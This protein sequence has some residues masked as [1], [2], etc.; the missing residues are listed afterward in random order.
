M[1]EPGTALY[2]SKD[3]RTLE[4]QAGAGQLMEKAGMAVAELARDLLESHEDSILIIA[5]PGNNGGDAL[6][7]ARYLKQNWHK[8]T[9]ALIAEPSKLP[10]DAAVACDAWIAAGGSLHAHIPDHTRFELVIDGLFGIGLQRPLQGAYADIVSQINQLTC[11]ILSI[12]TPSGLDADT[13]RILGAAVKASH[14]LTFLGLKPGLYTLEGPDH[15]GTIL[16]SDLGVEADK[17]IASPGRLLEQ[18]MFI[19]ALPPR[20][21]NSHK[22]TFGS[23]A[24]VGG[25]E[26]MTGAALLSARAALLIGSG[27]VYAGLLSDSAPL[28]DPLHPELMLRRAAGLEQNVEASCA[29]VGPG[30]GRSSQARRSLETWLQQPVPLVLDADALQLIGM[31]AAIRS[32]LQKRSHASVITPHPGEAARLLGRSTAEI[33][34]DRIASALQLAHELRVSVVLKG[35]GT[36]CAEPNGDWYIN[37]TGNPGLASAGTGDVLAGIIGGLVA[38]GLEA[39]HAARLGVYLHGAAADALVAQGTGLVGLTASEI[40]LKS[41]ELINQMA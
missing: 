12:D 23:V 31:H 40:A 30:L 22:G 37:T 15:A 10:T 39:S 6:V 26:G 7:A 20:P 11:P 8:V 24:V 1:P 38:Q 41:R 13:G 17:F 3:I 33:Q 2:L 25:S 19:P 18:Q 34:Q 28:I 27:R 32:L 5:G 14:T 4:Q 9:V 21:R 29:V 35:A 16:F 36:V